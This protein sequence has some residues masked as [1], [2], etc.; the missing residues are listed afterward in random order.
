VGPAGSGKSTLSRA[1]TNLGRPHIKVDQVLVGPAWRLSPE[2]FRARMAV[3]AQGESWI[4]DGNVVIADVYSAVPEVWE[5][6]DTIVWLDFSRRVIIP[7]LI[8]RTA[9]R[10]YRRMN[11]H[12]GTQQSWHDLFVLDPDRSVIAWTWFEQPYLREAYQRT[13]RDPRWSDR[14]VRLRTRRDV[15]AFTRALERQGERGAPTGSHGAPGVISAQAA[16]AVVVGPDRDASP[17]R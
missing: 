2:Q 17:A 6:A 9:R 5:R 8:V 12:D 7:R 13:T 3:I 1:L 10:A 15:R 16:T 4:I 14:V 11:L